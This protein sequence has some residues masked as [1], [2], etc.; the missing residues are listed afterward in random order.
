MKKSGVTKVNIDTSTDT[1]YVAGELYATRFTVI[2]NAAN[3]VTFGASITVDGN[4]TLR[5]TAVSGYIYWGSVYLGYNGTTLYASTNFACAGALTTSGYATINGQFQN[6]AVGNLEHAIFNLGGSSN[7]SKFYIKDNGTIR[8]TFDPSVPLL[9]LT[10][11]LTM[12][13]TLTGATTITSAS[14]V[15]VTATGATSDLTL[16]A[17]DDIHITTGSTTSNFL[18]LN[19]GSNI[20]LSDLAAGQSVYLFVRSGAPSSGDG[21]T[22]SLWLS[23]GGSLYFKQSGGWRRIDNWVT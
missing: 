23:T 1:Y 18:N 13:G 10:G 8:L 5:P 14:S 19:F 4:I 7:T 20:I 6:E 9:T 21:V 11:G 3:S 12:A 17:G 16:S 22:G 15:S 2:A